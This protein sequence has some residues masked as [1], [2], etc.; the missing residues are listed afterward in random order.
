MR[1]AFGSEARTWSQMILKVSSLT[2]LSMIYVD[3]ILLVAAVVHNMGNLE[4]AAG[5][6]ELAKENFD[7]AVSIRVK[8][9][10]T[11]ANQLALLYLCI[12][13]VHHLEGDY[14]EAMKTYAKAEN[15]FVRT[16]GAEKH[17]M[18]Q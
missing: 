17:Y 2:N 9:G 3:N 5:N 14:D 6:Y 16:L 11:A 15:L 13:R 8:Q 7:R 18:A 12:G 10:E 1:K 4:S